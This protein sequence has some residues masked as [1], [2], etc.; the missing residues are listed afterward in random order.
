MPGRVFLEEPV[1]T[2]TAVRR[3]P[4][5]TL[6]Q[7]LVGAAGLSGLGSAEPTPPQGGDVSVVT[8]LGGTIDTLSPNLEREYQTTAPSGWDVT[9][10]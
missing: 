9:I 10:R 5:I 3:L 6:D 4:D 2:L 1:G 7:L 8:L